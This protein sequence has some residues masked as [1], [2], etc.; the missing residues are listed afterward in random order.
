VGRSKAKEID[1][2]EYA[3]HVR[4]LADSH[5]DLARDLSAF[6]DIT[7]VL[8]WMQ[9]NGLARTA[10]DM[11]AQDEFEYDFLVQLAPAG[12]WASFGVT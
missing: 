1:P 5:A 8:T 2:V 9:K 10:V 4:A 3:D 6:T 11:V 7:T 12:E